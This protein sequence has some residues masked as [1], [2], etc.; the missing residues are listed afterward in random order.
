[1]LVLSLKPR[2]KLT[3]TG[4]QAGRQAE[5]QDRV[6]SQADALTKK[7]GVLKKIEMSGPPSIF[8][9]SSYQQ[10]TALLAHTPHN[11]LLCIIFSLLD[12]KTSRSYSAF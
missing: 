3:G 4:K 11:F 1:M 12:L 9:L 7:D 6:L 10:A 5:G 8:F 2:K